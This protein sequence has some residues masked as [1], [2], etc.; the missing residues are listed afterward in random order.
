MSLC[1]QLLYSDRLAFSFLTHSLF[2]HRS[3]TSTGLVS[4]IYWTSGF[5]SHSRTH[6]RPVC[7]CRRRSRS[8]RF[9]IWSTGRPR[10]GRCRTKT[11]RAKASSPLCTGVV[12]GVTTVF[13]RFKRS[14]QKL[15]QVWGKAR[16]TADLP[17]VKVAPCTR[18]QCWDV[19]WLKVWVC[20]EDRNRG[21]LLHLDLRM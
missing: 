5:R 9:R 10:R 11:A 21:F 7:D 13:L 17:G 2:K 1:D 14:T 3:V 6:R 8:V 20:F 16:Q 18:L 4:H 19:M 15:A 12:L